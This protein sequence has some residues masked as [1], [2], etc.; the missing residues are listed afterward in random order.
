MPYND[1]PYR[2]DRSEVNRRYPSTLPSR[3]CKK[4]SFNFSKHQHDVTTSPIE[5]IIRHLRNP[6]EIDSLIRGQSFVPLVEGCEGLKNI[7]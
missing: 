4:K 7:D 2:I 5:T 3:T 6:R 1:Y